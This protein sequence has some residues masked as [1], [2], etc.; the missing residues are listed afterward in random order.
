MARKR[1]FEKRKHSGPTPAE[2]SGQQLRQKDLK[3][4]GS[5]RGGGP[6][7]NATKHEGVT[8]SPTDT[9]SAEDS[10]SSEESLC[11]EETMPPTKALA[12]T[13]MKGGAPPLGDITKPPVKMPNVPNPYL[14]N[15]SGIGKFVVPKASILHR[16]PTQKVRTMTTPSQRKPPIIRRDTGGKSWPPTKGMMATS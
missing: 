7:L 13:G 12:I 11:S 3:T 14:K 4:D 2:A 9:R 5:Q 16:P 15:R 1:E 8:G 6:T 10:S